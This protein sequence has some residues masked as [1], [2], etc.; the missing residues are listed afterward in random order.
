M[1]AATTGLQK[2]VD[3]T[4]SMQQTKTNKNIEELSVPQRKCIL[5]NEL[6][7]KHFSNEP[8]TFSNCMK[9]CRIDQAL[10]ICGC[11]PP[12]Y[13]LNQFN[14]ITHCDIQSLKCLKDEKVLDI[15][16]CSHCELSCEFTIFSVE[17]IHTL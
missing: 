2:F 5:K 13:R 4:V 12:F 3:V 11:L 15:R 9:D 10:N 1:P 17:S 6:K 7:L 16:K 14:N 8:Y